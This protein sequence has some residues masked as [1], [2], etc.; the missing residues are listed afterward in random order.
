MR[1]AFILLLLLCPLAGAPPSPAQET[2]PSG[3]TCCD[4]Q[5]I[6]AAMTEEAL[7]RIVAISL[8]DRT[9]PADYLSLQAY[10]NVH[11]LLPAGD[12]AQR[13]AF[14]RDRLRRAAAEADDARL[15]EF[16]ALIGNFVLGMSLEIGLTFQ[17]EHDKAMACS[18]RAGRLLAVLE[19][20]SPVDDISLSRALFHADMS[21]RELR[22]LRSLD[23]KWKAVPADS[24]PFEEFNIL[25]RN[26]A[27][28]AAD[29]DQSMV[30]RL[31]ER[32]RSA[33]PFL[34][35]FLE[36]YRGLAGGIRETARRISERL[37]FLEKAGEKKEEMQ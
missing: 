14:L 31:A 6:R 8:S 2:A 19:K 11:A 29:P 13:L 30:F 3:I 5:K 15:K 9:Q 24:S 20:D 7:A 34:E 1:G 12:A 23:G 21:E 27:G 28:I 26:A 37:A 32:Y 22:R 16:H 17:E 35:E 10:E 33:Y 25:K 4:E 18:E 36:A